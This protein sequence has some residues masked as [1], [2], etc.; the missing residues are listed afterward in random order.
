MKIKFMLAIK[1]YYFQLNTINTTYQ[2]HHLQNREK[3]INSK[4]HIHLISLSTHCTSS[5]PPPTSIEEPEDGN[6]K[7]VAENRKIISR[8][9]LFLSLHRMAKKEQKTPTT[10]RN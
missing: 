6:S 2:Y 7:N 5:S 4:S 3:I 8:I 1:I 10:R 9:T